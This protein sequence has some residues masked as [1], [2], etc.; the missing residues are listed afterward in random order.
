[1][2]SLHHWVSAIALAAALAIAARAQTPEA[3]PPLNPALP[4]LFVVGDSTAADNHDARAVG[5]GVIFPKYFDLTKVN[6]ANRARGG[7][8]SRTFVTEGLWE[9]VL[10]EVK[11][12]DVVLLQFGHNDGGPVNDHFRA[13]GSIPGLGEETEAIDNFLTKKHEVIHTFGWYMRLM[14]SQAKLKG[15]TPIVLGLT[16]RDIW[17][18]GRV[19]R[20]PGSYSIWSAEVARS[21]GVPFLDLTDWIANR[22]EELGQAKVKGFFPRDHTHTSAAGAEL[23]ASFVAVGLRD[24]PSHPLAGDFS[25]PGQALPPISGP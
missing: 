12:G 23:N 16:V 19:E 22:Y 11:P 24:M 25:L 17:T 14:V 4:T 15:A 7:R 10:S 20:G 8:S 9:K 2:K 6:V 21:E 5:W 1:M 18:N 3:P 13:R